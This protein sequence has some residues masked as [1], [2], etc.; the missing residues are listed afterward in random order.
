M[1]FRETQV[2][3]TRHESINTPGGKES[4][5]RRH[6]Q[7]GTFVLLV[8]LLVGCGHGPGRSLPVV[9]VAPVDSAVVEGAPATFTLTA[10]PTPRAEVVVSI[11]WTEEGSYITGTR[12]QTVV[13]GTSGTATTS[14]DTDDDDSAEADGSVT[15]AVNEGDSYRVGSTSVATV[16]VT[17]NDQE[18]LSEVTVAAVNTPVQE[19]A[20]AEFI[21]TV[22]PPPAAEIEVNLSWTEEGSYIT[23]TPPQTVV[24]GTSG[25]GTVA[26]D[27]EDDSIDEADGSVTLAVSEGDSY[28]VG[29]A[30]MATVTVIDD[31]SSGQV[32]TPTI[33]GP[34]TLSLVGSNDVSSSTLPGGSDTVYMVTWGATAGTSTD[35]DYEVT[36]TYPSSVGFRAADHYHWGFLVEVPGSLASCTVSIDPAPHPGSSER[37]DGELDY[38]AVG[39]DPVKEWGAT[40]ASADYVFDSSTD[41]V[42]FAKNNGLELKIDVSISCS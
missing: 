18:R 2:R 19:G 16:V 40:V 31:D 28:R 12:P 34:R 14:V 37:S 26:V 20:M 30:N 36:L 13:I 9:T 32:T 8:L 10:A 29:S 22:E 21:V 5:M 6:V 33:T 3:G 24:I 23:G 41:Y 39:T 4:V 27:T 11:S 17:D 42:Q 35:G 7:T 15:L 25:T 1:R 38:R